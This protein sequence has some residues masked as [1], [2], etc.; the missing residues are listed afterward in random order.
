MPPFVDA[1]SLPA[2]KT[3]VDIFLKN[4]HFCGKSQYA[5]INRQAIRA[6]AGAEHA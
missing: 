3:S 5:T 4:H 6:A 2:P 1:I